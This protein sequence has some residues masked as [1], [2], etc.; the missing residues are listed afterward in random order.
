ML[1]VLLVI[2]PVTPANSCWNLQP[3]MPWK[4]IA[5][6]EQQKD[7]ARRFVVEPNQLLGGQETAHTV[8]IVG[9]THRCALGTAVKYRSRVMSISENNS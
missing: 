2:A 7:G 3:N 8:E 6:G 5:Q 4:W 9:R 1:L